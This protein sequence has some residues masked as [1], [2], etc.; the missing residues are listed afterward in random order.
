MTESTERL[1][2]LKERRAEIRDRLDVLTEEDREVSREIG[3]R[4]ADGKDA[5]KTLRS[6]R[7][8]IRDETEDLTAAL[9]HLEREIEALEKKVRA[10]RIEAAHG[11]LQAVEEQAAEVGDAIRAGLRSLAEPLD[12]VAELDRE[13]KRAQLDVAGAEGRTGGGLANEPAARPMGIPNDTLRTLT[14]IVTEVS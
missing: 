13:Y 1:G 2:G 9:P 4:I 11:R 7:A 12:R 5:T 8:D 3:Q 10:G 14:D 6:K